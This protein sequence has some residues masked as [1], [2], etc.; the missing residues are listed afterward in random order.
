MNRP[1]AKALGVAFVILLLVVWQIGRRA[2]DSTS[3]SVHPGEPAQLAVDWNSGD[4]SPALHGELPSPTRAPTSSLAPDESEPQSTQVVDEFLRFVT[5]QREQ[6]DL[7]PEGFVAASAGESQIPGFFDDLPL[8]MEWEVQIERFGTLRQAARETGESQALKQ[9]LLA[10]VVD[11]PREALVALW[12]TLTGEEDRCDPEVFGVLH[13]RFRADLTGDSLPAWSRAYRSRLTFTGRCPGLEDAVFSDLLL[14]IHDLEGP[15][16]VSVWVTLATSFPWS[17]ALGQHILQGLQDP[18]TA[19][20]AIECLMLFAAAGDVDLGSWLGS[21]PELVQSLISGDMGEV[22]R[23]TAISMLAAQGGPWGFGVLD[24]ALTHPAT[25]VARRVEL[26]GF[27]GAERNPV[28]WSYFLDLTSDPDAEIAEAALRAVGIRAHGNDEAFEWLCTETLSGSDES[29]KRRALAGLASAS[30]PETAAFVAAHVLPHATGELKLDAVRVY[31]DQPGAEPE[32]LAGM[33]DFTRE[34]DVEVR[35]AAFFG[36]A[37]T[38]MDLAQ[39]AALAE[40]LMRDPDPELSFAC[41]FVTEVWLTRK[42]GDDESL[43]RWAQLQTP[44]YRMMRSLAG[45]QIDEWLAQAA[46]PEAVSNARFQAA[47]FRGS[48]LQRQADQQFFMLN[49]L[50]QIRSP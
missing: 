13:A 39:T 33:T 38:A 19:W 14:F 36:H 20:G 34:P 11:E 28:P 16:Q 48:L 25:P 3:P 46:A 30:R 49:L 8:R 41:G 47:L 31:A 17:N 23:A 32:V 40:G 18:E 6:F 26:I 44:G 43:A 2:P 29:V 50:D 21:H 22:E 12:V 10:T 24:L 9:A 27:L 5:E 7:D 42:L 45:S 4:S 1:V 37:R 15:E 35:V